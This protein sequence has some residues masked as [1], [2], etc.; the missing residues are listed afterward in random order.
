[1]P[2]QLMLTWKT[3]KDGEKEYIHVIIMVDGIISF[4]SWESRGGVGRVGSS[5]GAVGKVI[6]EGSKRDLAVREGVDAT[7]VT[8]KA[9][10]SERQRAVR[11]WC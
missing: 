8:A 7:A 4:G 6:L 2:S 9:E 11:N 3:C 10:L 5:I 1:M